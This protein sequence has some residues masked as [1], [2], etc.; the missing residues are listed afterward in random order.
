MPLLLVLFGVATVAF[1]LTMLEEH[2]R[3]ESRKRG[4]PVP[5]RPGDIVDARFYPDDVVV[6][7]Y[8]EHEAYEAHVYW[9]AQYI[10]Q[11]GGF[12]TVD[13]A[14]DWGRGF[15]RQKGAAV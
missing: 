11:A 1:G 7:I 5:Q 12:Y 3:R 2:L 4:R 8:G 10:G 15:A 13:Q 6:K 9:R 14:A